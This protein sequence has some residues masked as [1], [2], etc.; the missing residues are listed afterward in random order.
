MGTSLVLEE[1]PLPDGQ[2][3]ETSEVGLQGFSGISVKS[4][5]EKSRLWLP[6]RLVPKRRMCGLGNFSSLL[7]MKRDSVSHR[8]RPNIICAGDRLQSKSGVLRSCSM[9]HRKR[10]WS[11]LPV[12]SA[13]NFR[14]RLAIFTATSALPLNCGK[15]TEDRQCCTSHKRRKFSVSLL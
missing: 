2:R 12:G 7:M 9:A 6:A 15:A 14:W 3:A 4:L 8:G 10:S 13:F 1:H 11:R 5:L